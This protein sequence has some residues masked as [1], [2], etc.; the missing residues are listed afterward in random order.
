MNATQLPATTSQDS[1]RNSSTNWGQERR[2]EFIDFRL[3]WDH[4]FNRSDLTSHFGISVPQASLDIARYMQAAPNNML[5]DRSSRT[6]RSTS[7]YTSVI[8]DTSPQRYLDD[9][10]SCS[11]GLL[12]Q[13]D[14][15]LGWVPPIGSVPAL[16]RFIDGETLAI[17]VDA[18][19][20]KEMVQI[21]YQSDREP[22]PVDRIIS[23][24]AF[25]YDGLRWHVRAY[26][27]LRN[28]YRDFVL[29]RILTIRRS[30]LL[31][32][33]S[34]M[35]RSWYNILTLEIAPS[36]LLPEGNRRAVELEYSMTD[37]KT[38][39]QCRQALLYYIL[40]Q[41]GLGPF[42]MEKIERQQIVLSNE[43][44]IAPYISSIFSAR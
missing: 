23:P 10:L 31:G 37:G 18:I 17:L 21:T 4:V 36:P 14:T 1:E 3:R 6:Y 15:Y 39:I 2:L 29:G 34:E 22:L 44:E 30:E 25:G 8:G 43:D 7:A 40:R 41:L 5:Y 28:D 9:A 19:R 20:Y 33:D 27:T 13:R 12:D 26:C 11:R 38:T 16:A 32:I 35:D 42:K 24:H